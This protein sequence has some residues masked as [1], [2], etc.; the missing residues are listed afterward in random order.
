MVIS[1]SRSVSLVFRFQFYFIS[2]NFI[3][4][5]LFEFVTITIFAHHHSVP[6]ETGWV[7]DHSMKQKMKRSN[8]KKNIFIYIYKSNKNASQNE[9]F[10]WIDRSTFVQRLSLW[11]ISIV[12]SLRCSATEQREKK[13]KIFCMTHRVWYIALNDINSN[14][15]CVLLFAFTLF[16]FYYVTLSR[17]EILLFFVV[18]CL[19]LSSCHRMCLMSRNDA[20]DWASTL[21]F[22]IGNF[23]F[24]FFSKEWSQSQHFS[25]IFYKKKIYSRL[26]LCVFILFALHIT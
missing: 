10:V 20:T 15:I 21:S 16:F 3:F 23:S 8:T 6:Y 18:V 19:S 22:S 25:C 9:E 4:R 12:I 5:Y 13:K 14:Y 7:V 26:I 2:T 11:W 1:I 24:F 17:Y